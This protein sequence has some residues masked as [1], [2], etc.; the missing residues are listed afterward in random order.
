MLITVFTMLIP[1]Q[2]LV[3]AAAIQNAANGVAK[4]SGWPMDH[5]PACLPSF[6]GSLQPL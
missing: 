1:E 6:I 3:A 5:L 2:S 4:D